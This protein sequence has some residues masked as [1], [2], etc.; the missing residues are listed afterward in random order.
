MEKLSADVTACAD[1]DNPIIID[2]SSWDRSVFAEKTELIKKA[3][4]QRRMIAFRYFS[5]NGESERRIEPYHLVFQWSSWYV[6][7]YCT[8]RGDYRMFKLTRMTELTVTD[9][10]CADRAVPG[11]ITD[12]LSHTEGEIKATVR[13]DV[14]VK[15]RIIDEFGI[16]ALKYND[17]GDIV[18]EFTWSD[19][20]SLFGHILTFGTRAEII[21]PL[22]YRREFAALAKEIYKKYQT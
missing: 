4:E 20:Q 8:G 22:E 7:G 18:I 16:D 12:K 15:W 13:F 6:W 19:K 1:T 21:E 3:I 2:L 9:E 17:D 10:K 5:P 14:S 11:Y